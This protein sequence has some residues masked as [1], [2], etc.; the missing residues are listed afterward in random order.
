[1]PRFEI[2]DAGV[3]RF[4][5]IQLRG[6]TCTTR[7]GKVGTDGRTTEKSFASRAA[8][9]QAFEKLVAEKVAQGYAERVATAA[10][11][12]ASTKGVSA[13]SPEMERAVL[14]D[15]RDD[16]GYLVYGDWLQSQ[17]DPRGELIA[18][19]A[20]RLDDPDSIKLE[21]D[22][23]TVFKTYA[24][25]LFGPMLRHTK[26]RRRQG[27]LPAFRWHLGFVRSATVSYAEPMSS[28]A[29]A[30]TAMLRHPSFRFLLEL[31]VGRTHRTDYNQR[32]RYDDVIAALVALGPLPLEELM[33]VDSSDL[34]EMSD[35]GDLSRL[36]PALPRL[37][38]LT[39]NGGSVRLGAIDAPALERLAVHVTG[40]EAA[41]LR[42]LAAARAPRLEALDLWFGHGTYRSAN[43]LPDAR[44]ILDGETFPGLVELAL[45]TATQGAAICAAL[46]RWKILPRLRSLDLSMCSI[47]EA[48]SQ[49]LAAAAGSL[50]HLER[51]VVDGERLGAGARRPLE[52]LANVVTT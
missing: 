29:G 14:A 24:E 9:K 43:P 36:W 6:K 35:L 41:T 44:P 11:G 23:A 39:L 3:K 16:A 2:D 10:A 48:G 13:V 42:E 33:L 1:M 45:G 12:G 28:L 37:R 51:V 31:G 21:R 52:R 32:A 8:A 20:A 17:G 5:D 15:P 46:P 47:D 19:H 18:I 40:L 30:I 38:R 7:W 4:W 27:S 49:A 34:L 25:E 26:I 22:E 50:A